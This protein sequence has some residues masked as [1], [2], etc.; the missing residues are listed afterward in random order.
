V[1]KRANSTHGK[2]EPHQDYS[3]VDQSKDICLN[4]WVPL[5]D[6]DLRNGCMR[7][8]DCSQ[9]FDHIS[10]TSMNPSVYSDL[11]PELEANYLTDLPMKAGEACIFDAR[12]LHATGENETDKERPAILFSMVPENVQP[13]LYFWTADEPTRLQVYEAETDFILHLPARRYP[14]PEEKVG[15][16]FQRY[17]DYAPTRWTVS[18]LEERLPRARPKT[19]PTVSAQQVAG[20]AF[21]PPPADAPPSGSRPSLLSRVTSFFTGGQGK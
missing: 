1:T 18:E 7:M 12:V 20:A 13:L 3:L 17:L 14:T 15:A 10:A 9:R 4:V 21:E 5:C 8:V 19:L 6:V 2:L 16:R 11:I